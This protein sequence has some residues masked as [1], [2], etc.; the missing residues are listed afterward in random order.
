MKRLKQKILDDN[1]LPTPSSTG[2][3][4]PCNS[5]STGNFTPS[6]SSS[7]GKSMPSTSSHAAR[8]NDTYVY[9]IGILAI[10]T[11]GV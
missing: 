7:T 2:N 11:I 10:L 5:S 9:G 6:T 8:S 3:S 4:A 1:K